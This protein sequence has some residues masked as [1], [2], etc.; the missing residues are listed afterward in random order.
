MAST[1]ESLIHVQRHNELHIVAQA[2]FLLPWRRVFNLSDS[3]L[4]V[5]KRENAKALFRAH[6]ESKGGKLQV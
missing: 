2:A 6:I 5:A 4:M 3:S 1:V